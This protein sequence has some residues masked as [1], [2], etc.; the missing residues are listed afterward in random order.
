MKC[1]AIN[2]MS[3]QLSVVLCVQYFATVDPEVR[4]S[5]NNMPWISTSSVMGQPLKVAMATDYTHPHKADDITSLLLGTLGP[6]D[7]STNVRDPLIG[8]VSSGVDEGVGGLVTCTACQ[9]SGEPVQ[10]QRIASRCYCQIFYV[11]YS[12]DRE[13]SSHPASKVSVRRG[14]M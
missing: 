2:M 3:H 4:V 13:S 6:Q 11:T 5:T 8:G 14:G 1:H 10:L 9:E 7:S 12:Q